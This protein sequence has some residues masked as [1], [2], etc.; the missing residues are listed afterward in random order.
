MSRCRSCNAPI[1]WARTAA[2]KAMPLDAAPAAG[3]NVILEA[4]GGQA[5]LFADPPPAEELTARVLTGG[6]LEA[7][8][9]GKVA[10]WMPH[11]AT[12]PDAARHRRAR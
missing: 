9:D 6:D 11:H 4:A 5:V 8:K 3:G 2:G 12:C 7:A 1:R 10:L